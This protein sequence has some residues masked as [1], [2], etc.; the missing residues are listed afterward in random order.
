MTY[1]TPL[2]VRNQVNH[3][4]LRNA[5]RAADPVTDDILEV[6][7]VTPAASP[8]R[9]ASRAL[10]I[11][12]RMVA[13][14]VAGAVGASALFAFAF[15]AR[16]NDLDSGVDVAAAIPAA[17]MSAAAESFEDRSEDVSRNAV[18]SGL[19]DV[20]A[21]KAA[22][23]R[24]EQL[25]AANQ[26]ATQAQAD[27]SMGERDKLMDAD[28]ELVAAQSQ[29]LKEE[30]EK[31]AKLLER[32]R[33]AASAAKA[34]GINV[35]DVES[36]TAEDVDNLTSKGGSMPVKSGYR[37]GAGFGQRGKWSRYH[38]GQDFP[39]P[40]GTPIYA[41]ASGVVL[42]P[43]AGGW[44]GTNVVIQHN[45][46]GST[47]YAHMSRKAVR[48]GQTVKAGQLIGYVGNTGRSFGSH[49]HFEYYKPG[50]TPGD[51]YSASNPM[52][53]LRS[54]GVSK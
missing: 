37:V 30:A 5:R 10:G 3:S 22:Q 15:T 4:P 47:L 27:L 28:M 49:L 50:V 41:A 40:T 14:G 8:A 11:S 33:K 53:F 51:V 17:A 46:G 19:T 20:V 25:G 29:K 21:D 45:N 35:G 54:L 13:M 38:T 2:D 48:T 36:M 26:S 32:A 44:A 18:R 12:R 6:E 9:R 39:A 16:G 1:R 42:S 43:T 7:V 24:Q 23:E 31:A 52:V 34:Q